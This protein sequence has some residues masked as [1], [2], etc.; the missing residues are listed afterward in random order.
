MAYM[1]VRMNKL[2]SPDRPPWVPLCRPCA[3]KAPR[4]LRFARET[5]KRQA[6]PFQCGAVKQPRT[7]SIAKSQSLDA[8]ARLLFAQRE[9]VIRAQHHAVVP[10]HIQ[11]ITQGLRVVHAGIE[12][13]SRKILA[14][15]AR[16]VGGDQIGP[17][18][19]AMFDAADGEGETAAAVREGDADR[20]SV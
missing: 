15:V 18:L 9:G 8:A 5:R 12:E 13:Q 10:D 20:K 11:Q 16:V 3:A 14:R 7:V 4:A 6:Q 17:H 2:T 1:D 19:E